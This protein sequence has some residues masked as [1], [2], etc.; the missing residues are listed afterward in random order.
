MRRADD[1]KPTLPPGA[2]AT[3]R[4]TAEARARGSWLLPNRHVFEV[5]PDGL[6]LG[7][8][9]FAGL[10]VV[11]LADLAR[12]FVPDRGRAPKQRGRPRAVAERLAL[13]L[14]AMLALREGRARSLRAALRAELR[15]AGVPRDRREGKIKQGERDK[16]WIESVP[17][18]AAMLD[19]AA[20][21]LDAER[22]G[23]RVVIRV[24]ASAVPARGSARVAAAGSSIAAADPVPA[25]GASTASAAGAALRVGVLTANAP[26]MI[27]D[28]LI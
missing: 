9:V 11:A 25:R 27:V 12:C 10:P 5:P 3:R 24:D 7:G 17:Q 2:D 13:A 4:R 18:G 1:D 15:D 20:R 26:R 28:R 23:L 16:R 14:R 22:E 8:H 21:L 6:L 19:L